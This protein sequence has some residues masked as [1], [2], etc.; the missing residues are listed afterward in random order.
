M[1]KEWFTESNYVVVL[2][3]KDESALFKLKER[4]EKKGAIMSCFFEP[5]LGNEMTSIALAPNDISRRLTSSLR[6]M[7]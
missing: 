1:A 7:K 4:A 2:V 5:D 6:L 3:I